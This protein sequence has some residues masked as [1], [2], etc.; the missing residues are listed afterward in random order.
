MQFKMLPHAD[1]RGRQLGDKEKDR[2][3]D[4]GVNSFLLTAQGEK[5]L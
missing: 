2:A 4:K 1:E 5:W 3:F